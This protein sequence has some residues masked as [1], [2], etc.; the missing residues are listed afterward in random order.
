MINTF[1]QALNLMIT[2]H[3]ACIFLISLHFFVKNP[4]FLLIS[5]HFS[6][7]GGLRRTFFPYSATHEQLFFRKCGRYCK[8][9][10]EPC[11]K[12][13]VLILFQQMTTIKKIN[14]SSQVNLK[15]KKFFYVSAS[16]HE[17]AFLIQAT[18][19]FFAQTQRSLII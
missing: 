1:N 14:K 18:S 6:N 3:C 8:K 4:F 17:L 15:N 9:A 12:Q 7:N 10:A 5:R 11:F 2:N 16:N 19:I 13:T